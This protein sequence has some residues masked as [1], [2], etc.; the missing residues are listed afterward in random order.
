MKKLFII[1]SFILLSACSQ[2][3]TTAE[4]TSEA[5]KT[6][7]KETVFSFNVNSLE[8]G[9][10]SDS[11][12]IC[13]INTTVK[14]ILNPEFTECEKNKDY[15]PS[16]VFMQDETLQRPTFQSYRIKKLNP[17]EDGAV[18]VYTQSSCNGNWFGLCNGNII[19]VMKNINSKWVVV[20]MYALEI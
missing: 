17:R 6:L 13:T 3:D 15:I 1:I 18:E 19:Y 5:Q 11:D 14:C 10:S 9:C 12:L 16:F 4:K 20:D 7:D 2:K 8:Q